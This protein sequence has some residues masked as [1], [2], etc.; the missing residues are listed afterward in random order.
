MGVKA[1]KTSTAL[2]SD[3]SRRL[4]DV[5]TNDDQNQEKLVAS[6][7]NAYGS[8]S[9]DNQE[10]GSDTP[11]NRRERAEQGQEPLTFAELTSVLKEIHDKGYGINPEKMA[12]SANTP[13][14]RLEFYESLRESGAD[15]A[16]IMRQLQEIRDEARSQKGFLSKAFNIFAS[17]DPL[18][19][20]AKDV[21]EFEMYCQKNHITFD[22]VR[23]QLVPGEKPKTVLNKLNENKFLIA[24]VG[25]TLAGVAGFD[26]AAYPVLNQI[27]GFFFTA[28]PYFAVPYIG[29]STFRAFSQRK[30]SDEV[31]NFAR[32]AGIMAAGIAVGFTTVTMMSGN[33]GTL[34]VGTA[35]EQAQEVAVRD[36]GA[37][38]NYL[39]RAIQNVV[40]WGKQCSP[41]QILLHVI[42]GSFALSSLYKLARDKGANTEN[43]LLRS[44]SNATVT[45]GKVTD[46]IND[47]FEKS[48]INFINYAGGPAIFLLLS[49]TM[50]QG[51]FSKLPEYAGYYGTVSLAMAGCVTMMA[52]MAYAYGARKQGLKEMGN[53]FK[54]AFLLSSSSATMPFTKK[55]MKNLGVREEIRDAVTTEGA[56]FNMTGT[57]QYIGLTGLCAAYMFGQD[58]TAAQGIG[59]MMTSLITAFGAPGIPASSIAFMSPVLQNLGFSPE[60][61]ATVFAMIAVPDRIFDMLQTGNNVTGDVIVAL[62]AEASA[63]GKGVKGAVHK[64]FKR[65]AQKQ[66]D[67]EIAGK[68]DAIIESLEDHG[69]RQITDQTEPANNNE[70]AEDASRWIQNKG[71]LPADPPRPIDPGL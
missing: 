32:F 69:A 39:D 44:L 46:K 12:D 25:G 20:A 18:E 14:A 29:L 1:F 4:F 68:V 52:G 71:A 62:D 55:T 67:P 70:P 31:G 23:K 5:L 54:T 26:P 41:G 6:I 2:K 21:V 63:Q 9:N 13:F 35:L 10:E 27:P 58:V 48:F 47:K 3:F 19:K 53:L 60:Q 38:L 17:K 64:L 33:L 50:A 42:G 56:T 16:D 45:A 22:E 40:G 15:G 65:I 24:A 34:E 7:L 8:P 49:T 11:G 43:N 66:D 37:L 28:L 57:A 59:I 51:G 30:L 61:M 36:G